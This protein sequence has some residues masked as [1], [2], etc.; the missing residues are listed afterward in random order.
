MAFAA[1]IPL[2]AAG[3]SAIGANMAARKGSKVPGPLKRQA[4]AEA[5]ATEFRTEEVQKLMALL[6]QLAG[7]TLTENRPPTFSLPDSLGGSQFEPGFFEQLQPNAGFNKAMALLGL[8]PT[9]GSAAANLAGAQ[10]LGG[11]QNFAQQAAIAAG[12]EPIVNQILK[13]LLAPKPLQPGSPVSLEKFQQAPFTGGNTVL[14]LRT[15]G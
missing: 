11:Q 13:D 2:I 8:T 4:R 5:E 6:Y 14:D 1:F 10:R 9:G 7:P 3:V 15:G 12:A